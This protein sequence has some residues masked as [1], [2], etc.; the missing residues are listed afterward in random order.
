[1]DERRKTCFRCGQ[2]K[3]WGEFYAHPMTGDGRLG[4][5]KECTKAEVRA[6]RER[7]SWYYL[8]SDIRRRC[9]DP[10]RDE[11][12]SYG[13]RGVT[14]CLRWHD[15]TAM[16]GDMGPRPT[17]KHSIDRIDNNG[18]YW[19]G[20]CDECADAGRPMNC[21]WATRT[22]Q[23]NNRRSNRM[24]TLGNETMTL[25]Q[26]AHRQC[27]PVGL[28]W[29]RLERGWPMERALATPRRRTA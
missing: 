10:R 2:S 29:E 23:A 8:W 18:G 21:R 27:I 14:L 12:P 11:Y 3:P 22:E 7:R 4:K 1:M 9:E 28:L 15:H 20:R 24:L 25:A 5:C 16:A 13:G 17:P 19:C 6:N 26:W